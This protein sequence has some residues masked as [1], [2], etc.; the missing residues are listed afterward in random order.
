MELRVPLGA[1][2]TGATAEAGFPLYDTPAEG[3]LRASGLN[4]DLSGLTLASSVPILD[5]SGEALGAITVYGDT[6]L[7]SDDKSVL[8]RAA[9]EATASMA[10]LSSVPHPLSV[11]PASPPARAA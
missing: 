2:V 1:G 10:A 11:G 5:H 7:S 3:D 9:A 4:A 6:P 8:L